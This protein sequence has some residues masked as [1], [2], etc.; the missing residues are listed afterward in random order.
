MKEEQQEEPQQ[1]TETKQ[2]PESRS[3][4]EEQT[5]LWIFQDERQ[6]LMKQESST[7]VVT[8]SYEGIV[9][10]VPELLQSVDTKEEPEPVPVKEEHEEPESVHIKEEQEDLYS[11]QDGDQLVVKQETDSFLVTPTYEQK[12]TSEPEPN[13]NQLLSANRPEA[14]PPFPVEAQLTVMDL[15]QQDAAKSL[16]LCQLC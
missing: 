11:N 12:V 6:L 1:M 5:E 13:K 16:K 8:C 10:P 7:S 14:A 15:N 4:K 3:I 2:E 9:H